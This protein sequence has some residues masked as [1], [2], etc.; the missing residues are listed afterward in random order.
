MG[1]FDINLKIKY[2]NKLMNGTPRKILNC[3][4]ARSYG[5]NIVSSLDDRLEETICDFKNN[6]TYYCNN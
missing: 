5:W 2:Q 1:K 3:N 4:L 6:Y